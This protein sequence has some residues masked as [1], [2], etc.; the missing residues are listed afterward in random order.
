[1]VRDK[2][3]LIFKYQ[4]N[5]GASLESYALYQTQKNEPEFFIVDSNV[6]HHF[7]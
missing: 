2:T 5:T 6:E 7:L 1:M 3:T 4:N